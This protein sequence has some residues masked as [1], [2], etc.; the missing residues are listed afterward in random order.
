MAHSTRYTWTLA[1]IDSFSTVDFRLR[2]IIP[3]GFLLV[4]MAFF[5]FIRDNS[6][7]PRLHLFSRRQFRG[8]VRLIVGP[9]GLRERLIDFVRPTAIV[10]NDLISDLAHGGPSYID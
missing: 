5:V 9:E 4:P 8:F 3:R 1:S 7:L 10:S 6:R 2:T